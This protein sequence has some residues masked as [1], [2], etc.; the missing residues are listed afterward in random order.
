[1]WGYTA[2]PKVGQ[3]PRHSFD[4]AEGPMSRAVIFLIIIIAIIVGALFVLSSRAHEVP[5][6][7][8]EIDVTNAAGH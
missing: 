6:N 7:T 3:K 5:T 8:V 4:T 1:V 2:A